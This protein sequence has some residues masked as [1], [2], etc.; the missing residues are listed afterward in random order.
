MK[1]RFWLAITLLVILT[2]AILSSRSATVKKAVVLTKKEAKANAVT[3]A[4]AGYVSDIYQ[5][6]GLKTTGLDY[7]VFQKAVTGYYNLKQNR[8]LATSSSVVAIVDFN[9]ASTQKRMWIVDLVKKQLLLNTWVAHGQGSGGDMPTQFSDR[10]ESHQSSLGFYVTDD[11]YYGKHGR[12]LRLDGMDSGFNS[13]ARS[14]AVVL[15]AADYVC[16][17]TIKQLGRLGRSFGCP[18]VSPEVSNKIIDLIKGKN[19]LYVNADV[20]G[21]TSKYLNENFVADFANPAD[22]SMAITKAGL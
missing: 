13:H 14:R 15:H 6:A 3:S 16:E 1:R 21:Y 22:S 10:N 12:S 8:K 20:N 18:A 11:V 9:K 7:P 4:Y 19:M 17:N 5:T 2:S